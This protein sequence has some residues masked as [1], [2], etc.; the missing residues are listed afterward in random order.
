MTTDQDMTQRIVAYHDQITVPRFDV[1]DDVLRGHRFLRRRR[2]LTATG[3][4]A[5][6]L[7]VAGAIGVLAPR[8]G[9][10][11]ALPALPTPTT[12]PTPEVTPTITPSASVTVIPVPTPT[13]VATA[14]PTVTPTRSRNPK[15]SDTPTP[16]RTPTSTSPTEADWSDPVTIAGKTYRARL[17]RSTGENNFDF[18]LRS[19]AT[20]V[21]SSKA[22]YNSEGRWRVDTSNPRVAYYLGGA[23]LVDLVSVRGEAVDDEVIGHVGVPTP[24]GRDI[25]GDPYMGLVVTVFRTSSANVP[26]AFGPDGWVVRFDNGGLWD[27][28]ER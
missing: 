27:L 6:A 28:A 11:D 3:A 21:F 8:T 22:V 5:A 1:E 2:I 16:T 17:T 20:T 4:A 23:K 15:P 26:S 13:A 9:D 12:S 19:G 18:E 7:V 10:G 24:E 14:T 25:V